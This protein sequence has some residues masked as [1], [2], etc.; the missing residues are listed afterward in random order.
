[1]QRLPILLFCLL[2]A[3]CFYPSTPD[4]SDTPAPVAHDGSLRI[5]ALDYNVG[6]IAVPEDIHRLTRGEI[7]IVPCGQFW[8]PHNYE[9]KMDVLRAANPNLKIIGYLGSKHIPLRWGSYSREEHPYFH[10]MF[11]AS[12]PYWA[13]TTTGD[14]LMDWPG[15][16]VFDVLNPEARGAIQDVFEHYQQVSSNKFD[17]VFWDYFANKLWIAPA[18]EGMEG[19]ADLDNNGIPHWDD[20]G[21]I[22]AF[23]DSQDDWVAEMQAAMG[24][25][26]I[27]VANGVRALQDS[28]FAAKFDGLF[29]E[30]F[31]NV[32]F[33]SGE[34][35]RRALDPN[36]PNNLWAAHGWP[37]TRNGG[38]WLI[39]SHNQPVGSYRE[40]DGG[41]SVINSGDLLRAVALLT[42]ATSLH[43]DN[44]GEFRAGVPQVELD[45]GIPL[46]PCEITGDRFIRRFERGR[47]ELL[48]GDGQ[49]PVPFA[50][51]IPQN[52]VIVEQFG[53]IAVSP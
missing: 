15:S 40:P 28:V 16:V 46:G 42:D 10:D 3:G 34:T 2:L 48:M 49:Y 7:L 5:A 21:E 11:Q 27:Q 19:E 23:L 9:G 14:T 17:G 36:R 8:G 38:P 22:Q 32:G 52:G 41:W 31:P 6:T 47:V 50:Y 53:E 1:M 13:T 4:D 43:Y 18:V 35:F 37:R 30:L 45:L 29:Y 51:A 44:T 33:S 39:L 25:D 20:P 26:F 24:A 12:L